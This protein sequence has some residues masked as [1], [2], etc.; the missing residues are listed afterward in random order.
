MVAQD[1]VEGNP[2]EQEVPSEKQDL[3]EAGEPGPSAT[4]P[5]SPASVSSAPQFLDTSDSEDSTS[6]WKQ[7]SPFRAMTPAELQQAEKYVK[8]VQVR[9]DELA[10]EQ[11]EAKQKVIVY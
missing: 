7:D 3:N 2:V 8:D 4:A 1:H 11:L 9:E 5:A 6:P 10:Q